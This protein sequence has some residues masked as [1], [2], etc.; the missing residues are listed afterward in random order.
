MKGWDGMRPRRP[1]L[2]LGECQAALEAARAEAADLHDKYVRMAAEAENVRK[3]AERDAAVL[4]A[5]RV[6]EFSLSLLE[7]ADNLE[8]ALAHAP[9]GDA[10]RPGVEAT[11]QQLKSALRQQGVEPIAVAPGI[12]FDPQL[13]EAIA[14]QPADVARET[15]LEVAQTGYTFDG[16]LLRPARVVVALPARSTADL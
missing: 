16:Q 5:R 13:H 7:V 8:R 1:G 9:L 2:S 4:G 6:R 14:G 11:L 3:R 12:P 15:V 10:L